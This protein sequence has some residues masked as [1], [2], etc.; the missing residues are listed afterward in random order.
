[1]IN[2]IGL[3]LGIVGVIF[4]FIWG[5]PQPQL[6]TG[7]PIGLEDATQ[8][9]KSGKTVADYNR[10]VKTRRKIH[11]VMSRL[12]LIFIMIGFGIQILGIWIPN[13]SYMP[14]KP[15]SNMEN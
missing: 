5:P 14:N 7:V 15:Y 8:I 1:M 12:G 11:R 6:E 4:I 9:D 10:E 13:K 3:S 2:T